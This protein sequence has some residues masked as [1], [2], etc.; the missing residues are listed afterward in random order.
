[1]VHRFGLITGFWLTACVAATV[2][3]GTARVLGMRGSRQGGHAHQPVSRPSGSVAS[4][5]KN[6]RHLPH[7]RVGRLM[8]VV[9]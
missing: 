7:W 1:M 2:A 4:P 3:V 5:G 9:P 8:S 6:A